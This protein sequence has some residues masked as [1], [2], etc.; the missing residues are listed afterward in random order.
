MSVDVDLVG[1]IGL[2]TDYEDLM[3]YVD[4]NDEEYK[5]DLKHGIFETYKNVVFLDYLPDGFTAYLDSMSAEYAY[6]GKKLFIEDSIFNGI[7]FSVTPDEFKVITD[8]VKHELDTL[9]I[10]YND[11]EIKLHIFSRYS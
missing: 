2:K 3:I 7:Y 10:K 8:D 5:D 9:G 6:V 1:I 11:D 4:K